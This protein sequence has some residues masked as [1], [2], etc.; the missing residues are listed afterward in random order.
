[1][2]L[3]GQFPSATPTPTE[4]PVAPVPDVSMPP[5]EPLVSDTPLHAPPPAIAI[6]PPAATLVALVP[7][8]TA[9]SPSG[10]SRDNAPAPHPVLPIPPDVRFVATPMPEYVIIDD[11]EEEDNDDHSSINYDDIMV[12][13]EQD[14]A[15]MDDEEEDPEEI[16]PMTD[17]E[18]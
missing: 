18:E 14:G 13:D 15:D 10:L 11:D 9:P 6:P 17:D 2:A 12:D 7:I 5:V 3:R 4:V 1:M 8:I 16:E